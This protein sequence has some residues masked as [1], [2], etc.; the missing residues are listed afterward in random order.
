MVAL[1]RI[2]GL[3]GSASDI[4]KVLSHL[5][6]AASDSD[7]ERSALE[8]RLIHKL[9]AHESLSTDDLLRLILAEIWT[10]IAK[11]VLSHLKLEVLP[12]SSFSAPNLIILNRN[13]QNHHGY[14]GV[15]RGLSPSS[16]FMPLAYM[17]RGKPRILFQIM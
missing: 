3:S 11:P 10:S 1:L 12:S 9:E 7:G 4:I 13:L 5:P 6:R 8:A 16:R 17:V 14:G 2:P 15:P